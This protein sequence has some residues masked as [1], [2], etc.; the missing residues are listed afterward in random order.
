MDS[1]EEELDGLY[2]LTRAA[3]DLSM[4]LLLGEVDPVIWTVIPDYR[5]DLEVFQLR[6]GQPQA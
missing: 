4:A 3:G 1:V 6:S 5:I 2:E